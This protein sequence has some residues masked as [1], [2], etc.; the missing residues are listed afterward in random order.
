MGYVANLYSNDGNTLSF[1]IQ[2]IS[3][4]V[5]TRKIQ[6]EYKEATTSTSFWVIN[7]NGVSQKITIPVVFDVQ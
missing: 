3:H 6:I 1:S 4:G 2:S 5:Y 7:Q